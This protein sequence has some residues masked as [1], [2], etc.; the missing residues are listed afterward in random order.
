MALFQNA[1][2]TEIKGSS[3]REIGLL[4]DRSFAKKR[5]LL[6]RYRALL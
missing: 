1:S 2:F 5:S 4:F 6:Q 3:A